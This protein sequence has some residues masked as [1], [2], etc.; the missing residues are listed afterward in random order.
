MQ[1]LVLFV[2]LVQ[3]Y[4]WRFLEALILNGFL[5]Q[6]IRKLWWQREPP[7]VSNFDHTKIYVARYVPTCIVN[8]IINLWLLQTSAGTFDRHNCSKMYLTTRIRYAVLLPALLGPATKRSK[9]DAKAKT[10][11]SW[12]GVNSLTP[13]CC[14][15]VSSN[16]IDRPIISGNSFAFGM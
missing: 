1:S 13:K 10:I 6:L 15:V 4:C 14:S 7:L 16:S 9:P 2:Q 3:Q 11:R 8:V 5:L 12:R